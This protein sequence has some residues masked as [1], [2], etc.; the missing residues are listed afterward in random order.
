LILYDLFVTERK[1]QKTGWVQ[2][3]YPKIP[4]DKKEGLCLEK[5]PTLGKVGKNSP[6]SK[7]IRAIYSNLL[8]GS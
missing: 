3:P 4:I 7:I 1:T 6:N 8:I 5:S 2:P